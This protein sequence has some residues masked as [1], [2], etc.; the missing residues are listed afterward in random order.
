MGSRRLLT[1]KNRTK[2]AGTQHEEALRGRQTLSTAYSTSPLSL[3]P[4]LL[5]LSQSKYNSTRN[6]F[7]KVSEKI[8]I[9]SQNHPFFRIKILPFARKASRHAEIIRHCKRRGNL[10]ILSIVS[11]LFFPLFWGAFR[12]VFMPLG[13]VLMFERSRRLSLP[14]YF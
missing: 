10:V 11:S 6:R 2:H 14:I 7:Y 8:L 12:W 9:S 4:S 13:R 5:C 3:P 1:E